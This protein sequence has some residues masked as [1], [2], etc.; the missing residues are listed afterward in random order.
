MF[1]ADASP[2]EPCPRYC[3]TSSNAQRCCLVLGVLL[4]SLV[5]CG[6]TRTTST[7]RTATEQL[8]ISDA[9]DRAVTQ[10]NFRVLA[11]QSVYLDDAALGSA[12]DRQYMSSS[13]RQH[14]LASGCTISEHRTDADFVVEARAGAVGTDSH[15]LMF[16]IPAIQI[17]DILA[18]DGTMPSAIPEVAVAKRQDQRG[19]VKLAVFAYHRESGMPVWQSGMAM[20]ESSARNLWV[21]GAGPFQ[22]GTIYDGTNFAGRDIKGALVM[23]DRGDEGESF[24]LGQQ[25]SFASPLLFEEEPVA[26]G[27][28]AEVANQPGGGGK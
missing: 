9:I 2:S 28:A 26:E 12:V 19:L 25:A 16:G 11:G 8:L 4:C 1:T 24:E 20:S 15:D 21:M 18:L 23:G 7:S 22:K 17:P 3:W 5:G 27:P 6:T 14:L 13:I 10:L